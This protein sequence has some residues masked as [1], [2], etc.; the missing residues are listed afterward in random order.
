MD[1]FLLVGNSYG[2]SIQKERVQHLLERLMHAALPA[3]HRHIF[4]LKNSP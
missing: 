1:F 3:A 4:K 2:G